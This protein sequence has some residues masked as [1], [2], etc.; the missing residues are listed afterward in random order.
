MI[1]LSALIGT[2]ILLKCWGRG[3]DMHDKAVTEQVK[4][5]EKIENLLN[6]I[7]N[8]DEVLENF[9][10]ILLEQNT[11]IKDVR[12]KYEITDEWEGQ[13]PVPPIEL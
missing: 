6:H 1:V 10:R 9:K 13:D 3:L 4:Y 8:Q 5:E 12:M 11:Y 2:Y 7:K